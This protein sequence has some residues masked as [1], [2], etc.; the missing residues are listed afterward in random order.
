MTE[1]KLMKEG[2]FPSGWNVM[3][4]CLKNGTT[5]SIDFSVVLELG[6]D[7]NTQRRRPSLYLTIS[8]LLFALM[9]QRVRE[10]G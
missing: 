4:R 2:Y 3:S 1:R 7:A 5:I 6:F 9:L 8:H 10:E